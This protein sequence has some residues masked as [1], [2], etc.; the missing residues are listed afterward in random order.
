MTQVVASTPLQ[1][2]DE[3]ILHQARCLVNP[4]PPELVLLKDIAV[5]TSGTPA[6]L[7]TVCG[8]VVQDETA[9][10]VGKGAQEVRNILLKEDDTTHSVALWNKS[11]RSPMKTGDKVTITH[12]SPRNDKFL[13]KLALSSTNDTTITIHVPPPS[14]IQGTIVGIE[15][16]EDG[17]LMVTVLTEDGDLAQYSLPSQQAS[18]LLKG[19]TIEKTLENINEKEYVF[20]LQGS[21]IQNLTST[22]PL[23]L[24]TTASSSASSS[25][26]STNTTT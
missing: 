16:E 21:V 2:I 20:S 12:V 19:A 26:T 15:E 11:S 3:G 7:V 9:H 18:T 13:W 22:L 8:E 14:T 5:P 17:C 1:N 23:S 4:P 6:P 25:S 10:V 24:P